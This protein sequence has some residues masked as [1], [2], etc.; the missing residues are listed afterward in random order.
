MNQ[1]PFDFVEDKSELV[2]RCNLEYG[3]WYQ[4]FNDEKLEVGHS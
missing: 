2:S 4:G 1:T 3:V